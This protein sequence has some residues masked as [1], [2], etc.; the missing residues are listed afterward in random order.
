M[1]RA[2]MTHVILD[3]AQLPIDRISAVRR[4]ERL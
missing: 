3:G 2:G 1:P 4:I